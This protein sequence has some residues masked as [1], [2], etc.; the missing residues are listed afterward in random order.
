MLKNALVTFLLLPF[1]LCACTS[2]HI[3]QPQPSYTVGVAL[4]AMN[5]QHWQ[6]IRSGMEEAAA[7]S[8]VQL[9]L[10]Y[11]KQEEATLEQEELISALMDSEIDAL[12]VAPCDSYHTAW[13]VEEAQ[14]KGI[15]SMAVDTRA[16]D[17]A[18]PYVG[19]D[20]T[21]I[22]Q[23]AATFLSQNL[24]PDSNIGVI[25]GSSSQSPHRERISGFSEQ[26]EQ[27]LPQAGI[28]IRYT[29]SSYVQGLEQSQIFLQANYEALFCTNAVTGL[30][31]AQM[32]TQ[33]NSNAFIV[34]VDTQDDA[35][36]AVM[37]GSIDALITQSGYEIGY[38]AILSIVTSLKTGQPPEDVL[39]PSQLLTQDN[40]TQFIQSPFLE[41]E[42]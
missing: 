33:L 12:I 2:I 9:L 30:A 36:Y 28:D 17:S 7:K 11:P 16:Y 32:Q 3:E 22:G 39:I 27:T 18:L 26:L 29:D 25:S 37:D 15:V 41:K 20:N 14:D 31:A 40:I 38:Q 13:F 10:L 4:K 24:H 34:A 6:E 23:L 1:L 42:K 35:L 19:A 21:K 5:S 8:N